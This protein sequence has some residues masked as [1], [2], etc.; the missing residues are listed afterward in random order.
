MEAFGPQTLMGRFSQLMAPAAL[1]GT[2][3]GL[4][5]FTDHRLFRH[6]LVGEFAACAVRQ[7]GRLPSRP[8][9]LILG[10]SRALL[11]VDPDLLESASGMTGRGVYNLGRVSRSQNRNHRF[12]QDLV[13]AGVRPRILVVEIGLE[14]LGAQST[15]LPDLGYRG[16]LTYGDLFM[17][18]T[19]TERVSLL[20]KVHHGASAVLIKLKT[21]LVHLFSGNA[22]KKYL[23]ARD[24]EADRRCLD[25]TDLF[26]GG[27]PARDLERQRAAYE[28]KFGPL[29]V[30]ED[31]GFYV[32]RSPRADIELHHLSRIRD[33]ARQHEIEL[34]F[35]HL[36]RA[37]QPPLSQEAARRLKDAVPEL[38]L[39]PAELVRQSWSYFLDRTHL[40][41][42]GAEL[43][44][45]WL[46]DVLVERA[47]GANGAT[48]VEES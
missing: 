3:F 27:N 29:H 40:N 39:P 32:G 25:G 18:L 22:I 13:N 38:L 14:Q 2:L 8:N 24:G 33:L 9:L 42:Q 20:R 37:F 1:L 23:S 26:E 6:S 12:F 11:G 15:S 34:L 45:S 16:I 5:V 46:A 4:L 30:A 7:T 36:G 10:S 17:R 31:D 35:V 41:P 48:L 21:S 28:Q 44:S 19:G 43:Y 47:S